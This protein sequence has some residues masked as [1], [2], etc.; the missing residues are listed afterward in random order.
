MGCSGRAHRLALYLCVADALLRPVLVCR[1][2]ARHEGA[3]S[4]RPGYRRLP[5]LMPAATETAGT[6]TFRP[7]GATINEKI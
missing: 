2:V 7:A 3:H 6:A 1:A 4:R 5:K